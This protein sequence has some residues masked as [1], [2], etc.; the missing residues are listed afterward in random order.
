MIEAYAKLQR[1]DH[2]TQADV[3]AAKKKAAARELKECEAA[4]AAFDAFVASCVAAGKEEDGVTWKKPYFNVDRLDAKE[5][6]GN[7]YSDGDLKAILRLLFP[8][9]GKLSKPIPEKIAHIRDPAKFNKPWTKTIIDAELELWRRKLVELQAAAED[10]A[11]RDGSND[12]NDE[13]VM[14]AQE[15]VAEQD[16]PVSL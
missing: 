1:D 2:K 13:A 15:D 8:G 5:G 6:S 4:V 9:S 10:V 3:S 7:L 11:Q 12:D 14:E 16:E